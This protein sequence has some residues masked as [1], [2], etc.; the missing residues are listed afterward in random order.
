M[1]KIV[2]PHCHN[3][4]EIDNQD[5]AAI[6]NQVRDKEWTYVKFLDTFF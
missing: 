3:T 6:L 1:N 5:Y 4:F 2:C